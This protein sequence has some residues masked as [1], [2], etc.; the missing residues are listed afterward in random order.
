MRGRVGAI[1]CYAG[2]V[3]RGAL[4]PGPSLRPWL[5]RCLRGADAPALAVVDQG[6]LGLVGRSLLA[7]LRPLE[8]PA[9][10]S[11]GGPIDLLVVITTL[12]APALP[13]EVSRLTAGA[14]VIECAHPPRWRLGDL[15]A[16]ARR[17]RGLRWSVER[18][19]R[20][21][22]AGGLYGLSQ[23]SPVEPGGVLVSDG[24]WRAR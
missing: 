18:R 24:R 13:A 11:V 3:D 15:L 1:P 16:P 7:A 10:A 5:R 2:R 22:L 4:L 17:A 19:A 6:G 23:W 9:A 8:I 12:A 21:W 14:R 20:I